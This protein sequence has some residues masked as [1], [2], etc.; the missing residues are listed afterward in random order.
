MMP[1]AERCLR[2]HSADVA[3][4]AAADRHV[5]GVRRADL[6][7]TVGVNSTTSPF[8][9]MKQFSS[10]T[11]VFCAVARSGKRSVGVVVAEAAAHF[12]HRECSQQY[13]AGF[14]QTLYNV[15]SKSKT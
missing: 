3:D 2:S 5:A 6:F 15:A 12:H 4:A 8:S 7:R 1:S 10:A 13:R 9:M 11:P 14:A